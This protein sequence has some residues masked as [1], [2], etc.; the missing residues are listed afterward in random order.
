MRPGEKG[1]VHG[2]AQAVELLERW[3]EEVRKGQIAYVGIV[4]AEWPD[5]LGFDNAGIAELEPLAVEAIDELSKKIE[6]GR[7]LRALPP[8]DRTL[9]ADHHCYGGGTAPIAWDFLVWLVDAE[10]QRRREGAPAPLKVAFWFPGDRTEPPGCERMFHNVVRP[11][12]P[13]IGAV[14]DPRAVL[15]RHKAV[16]V[17]REICASANAGQQVPMLAATATARAVVSSWFRDGPKPVVITLREAEHWPH[18]NSNMEGWIRFARDLKARGERVVFVRDTAKAGEAMSD[19]EFEVCPAAS[20]NV[21]VRLALYEQSKCSLFVSNGPAMQAVFSRVPHLVFLSLIPDDAYPCNRPGF[22]P[23]AY[24]I[25]DGGQFPWA[26]ADQRLIWAPDTYEN[27]SAAWEALRPALA[28][29][30]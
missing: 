8:R 29:A 9:G 15:G 6:E 16:Y 19:R 12:L 7:A 2:N 23:R 10:M 28:V 13:L 30:A 1:Q 11:L 21:D 20:V 27:I 18:R 14:E 17:A 4:T 5:V 3:L 26:R 25:P 22:F 24:G